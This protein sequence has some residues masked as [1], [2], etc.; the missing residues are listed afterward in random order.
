MLYDTHLSRYSL[1]YQ[2][3]DAATD[4]NKAA[5]D[6][7]SVIWN[8]V[9]PM[10]RVFTGEEDGFRK[11]HPI[12]EAGDSGNNLKCLKT[13]LYSFVIEGCGAGTQ[14]MPAYGAC[15][16]GLTYLLFLNSAT[17]AIRHDVVE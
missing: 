16:P 14:C 9:M 6:V 1:Q 7:Y 8:S 2:M 4:L 11:G 15:C 3:V 12:I 5:K 17:A 13:C 10:C